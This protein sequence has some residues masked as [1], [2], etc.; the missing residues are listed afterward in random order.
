MNG[1]D[2][3]FIMAA[4]N[5]KEKSIRTGKYS[6]L[7][8]ENTVNIFLRRAREFGILASNLSK[9]SKSWEVVKPLDFNLPCVVKWY[10]YCLSKA[11]RN[12]I[13]TGEWQVQRRS[14]KSSH[15][16]CDQEYSRSQFNNEEKGEIT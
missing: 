4:T 5:R 6:G 13:D 11:K 7:S 8:R 1:L 10:V 16:F 12:A 2:G 15:D 14:Q 3:F 9:L